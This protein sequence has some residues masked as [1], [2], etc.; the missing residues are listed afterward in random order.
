LRG[1]SWLTARRREFPLLVLLSVAVWL[2]FEGYNLHLVNWVYRGLPTRALV[3]DLGYFWSFA[4]IMPGV[5]E[6]ADFV[7]ALFERAAGLRAPGRRIPGR[8]AATRTSSAGPACS[9]GWR[10]PWSACRW[11]CPI[12]PQPTRSGPCGSASSLSIR[13]M[14]DRLPSIQ[15]SGPEGIGAPLALLRC[16][17]ADSCGDLESA[18]GPGQR[19]LLGVPA[20]GVACSAGAGQCPCWDCWVS[21]VCARVVRGLPTAAM[22]GDRLFGP[23]PPKSRLPGIDLIGQTDLPP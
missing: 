1:Q 16:C 21:T 15:Y 23:L 12:Q 19:R 5:F 3:R 10:S 9:G 7:E 8:R 17:C 11:R 4:T 14:T 18:G 6:T 20:P 13:S 22:L 2:V